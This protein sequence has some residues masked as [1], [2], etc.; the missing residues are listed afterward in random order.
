[1]LRQF[2]SNHLDY[3]RYGRNQDYRALRDMFR[4]STTRGRSAVDPELQRLLNGPGNLVGGDLRYLRLRNL[5]LPSGGR[6]DLRRNWARERPTYPD[7]AT[8]LVSLETD[9]QDRFVAITDE[10]AR[11]L[12]QMYPNSPEL[13]QDFRAYVGFV[14]NSYRVSA[15]WLGGIRGIRSLPVPRFDR[16]N[17]ENIYALVNVFLRYSFFTEAAGSGRASTGGGAG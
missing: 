3:A 4:Y 16:N 13:A 11:R 1:M 5:G 17:R 14:V 9:L 8:L 15:A 12:A 6:W 2:A 7:E 10:L